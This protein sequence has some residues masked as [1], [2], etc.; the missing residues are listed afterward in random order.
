MLFHWLAL[1]LATSVNLF[2]A[3][4]AGS[5]EYQQ[6]ETA[7]CFKKDRM[8]CFSVGRPND[9]FDKANEQRL[10]LLN[11]V[12]YNG[13]KQVIQI[14]VE[15]PKEVAEPVV[16]PE[17]DKESPCEEN[18]DPL[19]ASVTDSIRATAS[20][21]VQ[22]AQEIYKNLC[23]AA[24][25]IQ[26]MATNEKCPEPIKVHTH[27]KPKKCPTATPKCQALK[28]C[29]V[30]LD[31]RPNRSAFYVGAYSEKDFENAL[32]GVTELSPKI[33][34]MKMSKEEQEQVTKEEINRLTA[35]V[36]YS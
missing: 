13:G 16:E 15:C 1:G 25:Y 31:Q 17:K 27:V 34:Q 8:N 7:E 11:T 30:P 9:A 20:A 32:A 6:P 3:A 18:V 26:W 19:V 21:I 23:H 14:P 4:S 5:I 29:E 35:L 33:E 28:A 22:E 12:G 10:S 24:E 2:P 36:Q